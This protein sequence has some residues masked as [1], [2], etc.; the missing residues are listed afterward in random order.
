MNSTV[1]SLS[2]NCPYLFCLPARIRT[3]SQIILLLFASFSVLAQD[4]ETSKGVDASRGDYMGAVDT[5]YPDWFKTSFLDLEEDVAEAAVEG[6]RL[7]LLFHQN[8]CPY[9]NAFVEKNLAQKDIEQTLKTRFD[10]IEI[11]M[12]GDREVASVDDNVYTEK[13]FAAA[14]KVQFTPTILFLDEA[15]AL[16]L[17]LNG[18]HDPDRFRQALD[19]VNQ[20]LEKTGS[21]DAYIRQQTDQTSAKNLNERSYFTGPITQLVNRPGKGKKPLLLFFEQGSCRNCETLHDKVLSNNDSRS[22]LAEFDIYQVNLWGKN[23]FVTLDGTTATGREWSREIGISYA[24]TLIL[25]SADGEEVIRSEA[26]FKTFHTQSILDYVVSDA[27]RTQPSFQRYISARVEEQRER[28][29]DV[30]IWD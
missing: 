7:M 22:L 1:S 25:Y 10:V 5:T 14:L 19:F 13:A 30:N 17:R 15:G 3:L 26:W 4:S 27:W 23:P 24:P 21:F 16:A 6:K 8:G 29:I 12:W 18:Y 2:A 28:G 11:N 9:C 20:K